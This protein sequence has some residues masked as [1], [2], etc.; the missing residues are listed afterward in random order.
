MPADRLSNAVATVCNRRTPA[1]FMPAA[2]RCTLPPEHDGAQA[3]AFTLHDGSVVRLL[4][5]AHSVRAL[6]ETLAEGYFSNVDAGTQSPM[7][8]LMP[9]SPKS[10]PSEGV[11]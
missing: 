8:A 7:S 6:R 3:V 4:L 1:S 9:S 11:N 5:P 10:V 2:F